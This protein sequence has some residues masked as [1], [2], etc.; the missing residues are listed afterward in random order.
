VSACAHYYYTLV[1][2]LLSL[3]LNPSPNRHTK[4][5]AYMCGEE[6]VTCYYFD[7]AGTYINGVYNTYNHDGIHTIPKVTRDPLGNIRN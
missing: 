2:L 5:Y 6:I 4:V 1:V 3:L 7:L